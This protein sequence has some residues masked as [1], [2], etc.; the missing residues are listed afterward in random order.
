MQS[1]GQYTYEMKF[2]VALLLKIGWL[3]L[4]YPTTTKTGGWKLTRRLCD[5]PYLVALFQ[6]CRFLKNFSAEA[7]AALDEDC[8]MTDDATEM[9]DV[10]RTKETS[11]QIWRRLNEN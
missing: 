4:N 3:S 9:L 2:V 11:S 5:G 7:S 8:A 10:F 1:I 6:R